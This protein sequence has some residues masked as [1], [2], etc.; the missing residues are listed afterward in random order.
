[1]FYF[2]THRSLTSSQGGGSSCSVQRACPWSPTADVFRICT[3]WTVWC[4][5]R[6]L[7]R[8]K[9]VFSHECLFFP[10]LNSF[11]FFLV[12]KDKT[13]FHSWFFA[14][15]WDFESSLSKRMSKMPHFSHFVIGVIVAFELEQSSA[16]HPDF[17]RDDYRGIGRDLSA[18]DGR[19][20]SA[21][22]GRLS[23]SRTTAKIRRVKHRLS[24]HRQP[25]RCESGFWLS[26][27]FFFYFF[28]AAGIF[29]L[30]LWWSYVRCRVV[31]SS[32]I[33]CVVSICFC[34]VFT[35]FLRLRADQKRL[36][37]HVM[38]FLFSYFRVL[39]FLTFRS[40]FAWGK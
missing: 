31:C 33:C 21:N 5:Q 22:A 14:A 3:D 16:G 17:G 26:F 18:A 8:S 1:M 7:L 9:F 13:N 23:A 15:T 10:L 40:S 32:E 34:F 6:Y 19:R 39:L 25:G 27:V 12:D 30:I 24:H 4:C 28:C 2:V 38:L 35:S 37:R 20:Q 36:M 11:S 29:V